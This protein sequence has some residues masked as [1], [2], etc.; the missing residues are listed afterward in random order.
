MNINTDFIKYD[1]LNNEN[2]K[3]AYLTL[4]NDKKSSCNLFQVYSTIQE[5]R[6]YV[7][8]GKYE[9]FTNSEIVLEY[10]FLDIY[11]KICSRIIA[12]AEFDLYQI[13]PTSLYLDDIFNVITFSYDKNFYTSVNFKITDFF[14]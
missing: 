3:N 6:Y 14:N 1:F 2:I 11:K 9:R 7:C 13:T 4:K 8:I 5:D 10:L 12:I